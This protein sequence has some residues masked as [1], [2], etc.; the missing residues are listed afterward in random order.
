MRFRPS[1]VKP[2]SASV[3]TGI[4]KELGLLTN[5]FAMLVVETAA[6]KA[7]RRI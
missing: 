4:S 7:V 5:S 6:A 2:V 3:P 1:A